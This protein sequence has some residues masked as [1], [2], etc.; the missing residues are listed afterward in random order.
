[1]SEIRGYAVQSPTSP[2]EITKLK[3]KSISL[4]WKFMFIRARHETAN[5]GKQERLLNEVAALRQA[6]PER[7]APHFRRR[8]S[9][10]AS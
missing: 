1:M 8:L 10:H 4:H 5:M 6:W 7:M 9:W 3:P 2:L